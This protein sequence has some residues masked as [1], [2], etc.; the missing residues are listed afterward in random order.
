MKVDSGVI[1]KLEIGGASG[2]FSIHDA[3]TGLSNVQEKLLPTAP[4]PGHDSIEA[5]RSEDV[6]VEAEVK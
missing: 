1:G 4:S 5:P 6:S 2:I 3:E